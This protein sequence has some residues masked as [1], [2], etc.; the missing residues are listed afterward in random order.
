MEKVIKPYIP[1]QPKFQFEY[2]GE[3]PEKIL[4]FKELFIGRS[5]P[6]FFIQEAILYAGQRIGIV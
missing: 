2:T 5:E 6:L 1:K 3:S 4:T